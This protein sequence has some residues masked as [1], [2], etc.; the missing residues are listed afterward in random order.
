MGTT[1][2]SPVCWRS[3]VLWEPQVAARNKPKSAQN[4][5]SCGLT[6]G[7]VSTTQALFISALLDA[8][9]CWKGTYNHIKLYIF[10]EAAL[11]ALSSG[12]KTT[13]CTLQKQREHPLK[14]AGYWK[15]N[16]QTRDH[17]MSQ[18]NLVFQKRQWLVLHPP[19]NEMVLQ[20]WNLTSSLLPDFN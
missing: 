12:H 4:V 2:L 15:W 16:F 14:L 8:K 9:A 5:K 11:R 7:L 1:H 17:C 20:K 13:P 10:A 6:T 19:A 18:E 3:Q